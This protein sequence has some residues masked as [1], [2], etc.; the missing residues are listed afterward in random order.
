MEKKNLLHLHYFLEKNGFTPENLREYLDLRTN[1]E[2]L[3]FLSK[4]AALLEQLRRY[5]Y[6]VLNVS[7]SWGDDLE[8]YLRLLD[9][10]KLPTPFEIMYDDGERSGF[11]KL[12]KR[13]V[14]FRVQ[15]GIRD[16]FV[17]WDVLPDKLDYFEAEE[18]CEE[19]QIGGQKWHLADAF[20]LGCLQGKIEKISELQKLFSFPRFSEETRSY[21]FDLDEYWW[22]KKDSF[23][24]EIG[25]CALDMSHDN[26]YLT[27]VDPL[28]KFWVLPVSLI[29]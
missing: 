27:R 20:Y 13:P 26:C 6:N 22:C 5:A 15:D 12:D 29:E 16:C 10:G 8:E 1:L 2:N 19:L 23:G 11:V 7:L 17:C 24:G 9:A 3:V 4:N 21:F 28:S 18:Q 25:Y 14:A